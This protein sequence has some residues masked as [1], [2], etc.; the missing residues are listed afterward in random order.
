LVTPGKWVTGNFG[1]CTTIF[2]FSAVFQSTAR[3]STGGGLSAR[4]P[5]RQVPPPAPSIERCACDDCD[6]VCYA[7]I[8]LSKHAAVHAKNPK[9]ESAADDSPMFS[10]PKCAFSTAVR[11]ALRSHLLRGH[12]GRHVL[13]TYRCPYCEYES[14][15]GPSTEDHVDQ[16]HPGQ[17]CVFEVNRDVLVHV[18][19]P[20]TCLLCEET[21]A[22][23]CL[24]KSHV[25]EVHG[26]EGVE[27][28]KVV[29]L[30]D[31]YSFPEYTPSESLPS[32]PLTPTP[33]SP[34]HNGDST[35]GNSFEAMDTAEPPHVPPVGHI[36]KFH[37]DFCE[38]DTNDFP[39]FDQHMMTK[40][41]EEVAKEHRALH[42][43]PPDP[44]VVAPTSM[45]GTEERPFK[46]P[47]CPYSANNSKS[48]W[49]HTK[50]HER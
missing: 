50:N 35:D 41:G 32:L 23:A 19:Q 22:L 30:E 2:H 15:D 39:L 3:K 38:F 31:D 49:S 45:A 37:C 18:D 11:S 40:H 43:A 8:H 24:L 10:C 12:P 47:S 17:K 1:P 9:P 20:P 48:L 26:Q 42:P 5:S 14:L 7:A 28:H 21:F 44:V 6:Y 25:L 29:A 13:R 16:A 46:C 36:A 27:Q 4:G 33:T 34:E